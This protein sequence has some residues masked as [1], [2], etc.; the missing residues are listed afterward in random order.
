MLMERT[1]QLHN[2]IPGVIYVSLI[3]MD[4]TGQM[5]NHYYAACKIARES[6]VC[7][8][9]GSH[10]A[11]KNQYEKPS[12]SKAKHKS[13]M[14]ERR[15]IP[16]YLALTIQLRLEKINNIAADILQRSI[17]MSQRQTDYRSTPTLHDN[18]ALKLSHRGNLN[19]HY[20]F[21]NKHDSHSI[22]TIAHDIYKV[23]CFV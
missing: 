13:L 11:S 23:L 19:Q 21:T 9:L 3:N 16:Q 8:E 4:P 5:L 20:C 7:D 2:C 12:E 18:R 22:I 6:T 10:F 14:C 17:V 1:A 15:S